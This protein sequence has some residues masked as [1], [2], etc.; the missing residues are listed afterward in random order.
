MFGNSIETTL[1]KYFENIDDE[2]RNLGDTI[3]GGSDAEHP[4]PFVTVNHFETH[5]AHVLKRSLMEAITYAPL[6]DASQR[7]AWEEFSVQ[8]QGWIEDSRR[9]FLGRHT[10]V[11]PVYLPGGI[12]PFIYRHRDNIFTEPS[13][14]NQTYAPSWYLSPP[15]FNPAAVNFDVF[16]ESDY[17]AIIRHAILAAGSVLSPVMD[18]ERFSSHQVSDADHFHY[19]QQFSNIAAEASIG[20]DY[21][22]SLVAHPVFETFRNEKVVGILVGSIAWDAYLADLLPDGVNGVVCVLQ[23]VCGEGHVRHFT[24]ELNGKEVGGT[25]VGGG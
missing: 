16:S 2:L 15:P 14:A 25:R 21:P 7:E 5:G 24:Y 22:H 10:G 12:S 17:Q 4:F 8:H 23:S 13:P 20:Y 9:I 18:V 6:V 11:P 3:S 1:G 19:H